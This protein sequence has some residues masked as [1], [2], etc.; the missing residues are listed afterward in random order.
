[1]SQDNLEP[2]KPTE[3]IVCAET[4]AKIDRIEK[5]QIYQALALL[6]APPCEPQELG[7]PPWEPQELGAPPWEPVEKAMPKMKNV[8]VTLQL[9]TDLSV[10]DFRDAEK[11]R[12]WTLLKRPLE[13]RLIP[14]ACYK[15]TQSW[16]PRVTG[17][18]ER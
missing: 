9:R 18:L 16:R 5:R 7:A 17:D 6:A 13:T 3:A 8:T 1:M 2:H 4:I 11:W 15:Q 14:A 10:A 12:K